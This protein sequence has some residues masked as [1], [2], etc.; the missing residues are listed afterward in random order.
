[1]RD[2]IM[3]ATAPGVRIVAAVTTQLVEEARRR[4]DCFPVVAAA[5]GR[6]MTA[7]LLLAANL[8]TEESLTVR[9]AGDGPIGDIVADATAHGT[10]RGY[11]KN[12][13]VDIPLR[14]KK[15]DVGAAVGQGNVYVTRF[16]GLKQ[17]FTGNVPLVSGEIAEDITSYLAVS[18]QT[19]SSVALG[20]LVCPDMTVAAAGGF[21]VQAL[22]GHEEKSL[23]V[24]EANLANLAPVSQMV[25]EGKDA[26]GII[27][28]VLQGLPITW[29]DRAGIAFQCLCSREKVHN[30][31]ISLGKAELE[32]MIAEGKAEV[33]CHFC[34]EKYQFNRQELE[35]LLK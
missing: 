19:P 33:C 10:V 32:D 30:V 31:L 27:Q 24:I 18:E 6:T 21:I 20:V 17:P 23:Q 12:P 2:H 14:G 22:P 16:T 35:A 4:H 8:K 13:H 15:L 5:L 3:K 26:A 7:A 1:M 11:A 29:Y 25:D 34:A 28:M 9:I